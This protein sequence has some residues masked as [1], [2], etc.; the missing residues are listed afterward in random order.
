[1]TV[2]VA[3]LD[4]PLYTGPEVCRAT[5]I[6]YRQLDYWARQGYL[7]PEIEAAGQGSR[8]LYNRSQ[9]GIVLG[10]RRMLAAGLSFPLAFELAYRWE[11][12]GNRFG[13]GDGIV[14]HLSDTLFDVHAVQ[15]AT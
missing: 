13:I 2:Q 6:T 7:V 4:E 1:M 9:L 15:A 5:G 3:D 12:G 11:R 10:I 14:V 8:R